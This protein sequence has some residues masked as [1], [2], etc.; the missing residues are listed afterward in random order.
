MNTIAN[1]ATAGS[2]T[3]ADEE[4]GDVFLLWVLVWSELVAFGILICAFLVMSAL[5]PDRFAQA[6]LHLSP[7]L[8]AINTVVLLTSGWLAAIAARRN[9]TS[10]QTQRSLV[11]AAVFGFV[12]V[13]IK[14]FE[15]FGEAQYAADEA[16]SRFYEIYFIITGFHLL[17][18][19]FGSIVMLLV[20]MKPSRTNVLLITTLWHAVDLVWIV[21]FPIIYLA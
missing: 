8:A 6:R 13:G 2:A 15:Y 10:R 5:E 1:I 3:A 4:E 16:L 11:L 7:G 21:M 17:H 20:A 12:F 19:V 18:V 9:A 14:L